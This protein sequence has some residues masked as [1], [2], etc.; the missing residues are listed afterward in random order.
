MPAAR[1]LN[2]YSCRCKLLLFLFVVFFFF[3]VIFMSNSYHLSFAEMEAAGQ[4]AMVRAAMAR[5][6][7]EEKREK[8]K[9]GASSSAPKAIGKGALKRK[10]DRKDDHPLKSP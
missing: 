2:P 9:E 10:A 6:K 8:G 5:K 4:R 1:R 7:E 3:L